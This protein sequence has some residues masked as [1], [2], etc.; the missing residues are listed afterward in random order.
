M[1]SRVGQRPDTGRT[2]SRQSG[3]ALIYGMFVLVGGLAALFFLFNSGQLVREKTKLVDTADAV[4]YSA[5]VI[6]AKALNFASYNNR[7]LIA[8]E[9]LIAQAVSM[10]SWSEYVGEWNANLPS[11]HPECDGLAQ[12]ANGDFYSAF[13]SA[14][15]AMRKFGPD[16]AIACGLMRTDYGK[17][18]VD[19]IADQGVQLSSALLL[20]AEVEKTT[21][22]LS[23]AAVFASLVRD[24]DTFMQQV[25][26]A[27]YGGP[28]RVRVD[29]GLQAGLSDD[30]LGFT[31]RY[32]GNQRGRFKEVAVTAA[33]TDA[34]VKQRSW[35]S[36]A[37]VPEPGCLSVGRFVFS[38]VRRRGGTEMLGFDEWQAVDTQS[39][40]ERYMRKLRCRQQENATGWA[41]QQAQN[42][43]EDTGTSSFGGAQQ[44]TPDA[45][46][47]AAN[48]ASTLGNYSG[49]PAFFDVSQSNW[50][51]GSGAASQPVMRHG[52]RLVRSRRLLNTSDQASAVK[53]PPNSR[54]NRYPSDVAGGDMAAVSTA[55]VFFERPPASP[56]N[57]F[58]QATVGRPRELGS[59]FNPYWQV[60]LVP[61]TLIGPWALQGV[62]SL[63]W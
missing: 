14:L 62:A 11:V 17:D 50:L 1:S 52:V 61:S 24:R 7:A 39:F 57:A 63:P 2:R 20:A 8:S 38:E 33:H 3:Q 51:T 13:F 19:E 18:L 21:I 45:F 22:K 49:L 9:V 26:D 10:A 29:S 47:N 35:T 32:E 55:E 36:K 5:G 46:S 40:Q 23:Q 42:R 43:D 6:Q 27:N 58:G 30:W 54:I 53:A 12:A 59:L 34:F 60:R 48:N 44:D 25:A 56:S 37:V 15:A 31:Q 16:Y 41:S 28:S 4:A